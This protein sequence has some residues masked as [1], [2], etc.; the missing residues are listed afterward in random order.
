MINSFPFDEWT[1]DIAAF[2]TFGPG[3]STG[4]YIMT[5]LGIAAMVGALVGWAWLEEKKLSAQAA[6]LRAA[7][8]LPVP[9]GVPPGPGPTQ[10]PLAGPSTHPGE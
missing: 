6:L 2:W 8:G 4:T 7:G 3:G 5:V 1:E 9:G 10:P